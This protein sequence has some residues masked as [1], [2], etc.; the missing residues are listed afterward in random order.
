MS[1]DAVHIAF[2]YLEK[3]DAQQCACYFLKRRVRTKDDYVLGKRL[4]LTFS[5]TYGSQGVVRV[6]KLN[7]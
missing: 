1:A 4:G 7:S 5:Q 2:T 6:C 3:Q